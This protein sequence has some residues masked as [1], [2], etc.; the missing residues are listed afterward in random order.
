MRADA[1]KSSLSEES[2]EVFANL[3]EDVAARFVA[4]YTSEGTLPGQAAPPVDWPRCAAHLRLGRTRP[5]G[6]DQ[7][8]VIAPDGGAPVE[9]EALILLVVTE[10]RPFLVDTA[11]ARVKEMG[12]TVRGVSHPILSV[13]RDAEGVLIDLAP[14]GHEESWLSIEVYPPLGPWDDGRIPALLESVSAGLAASRLVEDD[15]DALRAAALRVAAVAYTRPTPP[16]VEGR[17]EEVG[18]LLTWLTQG[19]FTFFGYRH[20]RVEGDAI[21]P[22]VETGLGLLRHPAGAEFFA[23]LPGRDDRQLLVVTRDSRRSPLQRSGFLDYLGIREFSASGMIVGEHRFLGV[24]SPGSSSEPLSGVPVLGPKVSRVRELLGHDP[25]SHSGQVIEQTL[26]SFPRHVLFEG[27]P[28]TLAADIAKAAAIQER[29]AAGML[30][31]PGA[32][33]RFWTAVIYLP[34]DGYRTAV[35]ERVEKVL[36]AGL[37]GTSLEFQVAVT[38]APMARLMLVVK[39]DPESVRAPLDSAVLG[40]EVVAATRGW[41]EE[42]NE[43]AA[44]LPAQA[45]GV[46]FGEAYQSAHEP[47]QAVADLQLA[48]QLTRPDD[49]RFVMYRPD[50]PGDAADLRFKIIT[51]QPMSL[52]R[53]LPHLD[54]LGLDVWDERPF[55]WDLRGTPVSV[56]DFGF[57]LPAGQR[58]AD[59]TLA[60]RARFA[61]AFAA[62][63]Q[64]RTY[65]GKLNRLVMHAGLTWEQVSWLRGISRYL[66]Q[67]GIPFSQPYVADALTAHP[68]IAAA[69]VDA[70]AVRFDPARGGS[71]AERTAAFEDACAGIEASLEHV[72]NLDHDRIARLF[73]AVLKAMRRTNAFVPG[74]QT[75]A[76]KLDPTALDLLPHPRPAHE[77]FVAS[78]RV[79]GVHLRFGDVARGGL[80]WSDRPEDF[81]TEVLGLV[82]AQMVKNTVIVPVGAKGGFVPQRLP[83]PRLDRAAWLAEGQACYR[84]FIEAL[85]SVTD[86]L[87]AGVV[88]PADRVVSYDGD[89]TYLV[90]A[91]DKGTAAF[92]DLANEI[93]VRRGFWLGDAFAS[94]G[95]VGYDHKAMG[96]TARGAWESV[97]RHFYEAGLDCQEED[98]T[99]VGIGDMGG[100]VFGNGMLLSRH[101][102]LVGAFNHQHIFVDPDPDAAASFVERERLFRTPGTT[103]ADY[104]PSL[105][106][107]GGGVFSRAAKRIAISTQ[108]RT[109]LGLASD[110]TALTPTALISALLT[111]PVDLLW[112]GGIGTYV[113]ASGETHADVGDKANDAVRVNGAEV[114]ATVA[115]EGGNLG[116][117]QRGRI[118]YARAGGRINTDFIDNSAGVDTSDHEVNIKVLLQPAVSEQRLSAGE[119]ATLLASMT[120]DVARLVLAHNI[121]QN[122]ALSVEQAQKP[123]LLGAYETWLQHLERDAG[124]DRDLEGLPGREEMVRRIHDQAAWTR[125]ELAA[126]LAWT[127]IYLERLVVASALPDDPYLADRLTSYFPAPVR[128][129]FAADMARH[130][131]RREIVTTVTV[132]R[133]VNSQGVTA[134]S[135]LSEETGADVTEVIKAQLAARTIF[136]V[137]RFELKLPSLHLP[138]AAEVRVRVALQQMIER[139][140]RWLLHHRRGDLDIRAEA[141]TFTAGVGEVLRTFT[142]Y[143]TARQRTWMAHDVTA[144]EAS[145]VPHDIADASARALWA[146]QALPIV[147]L[148][149]TL[150]RPL[151]VVAGVYFGLAGVL[152]L[153]LVFER[154][155]A[156]DRSTRWDTM[157]RAA[158]RDD[159]TSVQSDL[160]SAALRAAPALSDPEQILAAW[161]E[162]I[163]GIGREAALLEEIT[164][165]EA[166]LARMSVAVRTA[167]T[168]LVGRT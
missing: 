49:L 70:L 117:T 32:Y 60:D 42:F 72:S 153:D 57:T 143:A 23:R 162:S 84:L 81:R 160:A 9:G 90:V 39:T 115:G 20:Y 97:K 6:T 111:A 135:R 41:A 47:W 129:R 3:G 15:A 64:G 94:G 74:Q 31:R 58:P 76:F 88:V 125:P 77:I 148:S 121:D 38:D 110:V 89:D 132:N 36:L 4:A 33:G 138:A 12:W 43:A 54:A 127:K 106:S 146:H 45:R 18:E 167:R 98:F 51:A 150:K 154:V 7:V 83:D 101:T 87:A 65:A 99:C 95:S 17:G 107:A 34:R 37:G 52:S 139:G 112:N 145:G 10:D 69:L 157:A 85:L 80:R 26:A 113:K 141:E 161:Q 96:I 119:R 133:F 147:D 123:S 59:W 140:T 156:L 104:D 16:G 44:D 108:M 30:L 53:V 29:G 155:N 128:E 55:L 28:E 93:A 78:P 131:L 24:P 166:T 103:W 25:A 75:F 114:R 67:A 62:S 91:A 116:W 21:E 105:I 158:L 63:Y 56:Y 82:K 86:N 73:L 159:L 8:A 46:I 48:N 2:E 137:A 1:K 68:R 120:D 151:D 118:E 136:A 124:L 27:D 102:R 22:D 126:I 144:L 14:G 35:R 100:D 79:E 5:P 163:G 109:A 134:F 152:G 142:Q 40:A 122:R 19:H 92:S 165:E 13:V 61:D 149:R 11:L 168:L 71:Q 164:G 50:D 130:P 66:R